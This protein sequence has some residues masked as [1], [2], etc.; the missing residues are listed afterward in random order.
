MF[1]PDTPR[2]VATSRFHATDLVNQSGLLPVSVS[3]GMP[4][5]PLAYGLVQKSP[6]RSMCAPWGLL[7]LDLDED[8]FQARYED[9]LNRIGADKIVAALEEL[10]SQHDAPG[11]V[12]LCW[13]DLRKP[14]TW[15]HRRHLA[16]YLE[17]GGAG[18]VPELGVS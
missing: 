11:C 13:E 4:S 6:V 15:C 8:E 3:I 18:T 1:N 2:R 10:A 5:W 7:H 16:A 14:D 17:H 12:L 9:R